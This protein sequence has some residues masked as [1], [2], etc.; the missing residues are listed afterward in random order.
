MYMFKKYAYPIL[1]LE[2]S[3]QKITRVSINT[4]IALLVQVLVVV[5]SLADVQGRIKNIP[6]IDTFTCSTTGFEPRFTLGYDRDKTLG[7]Q[8]WS[9]FLLTVCQMIRGCSHHH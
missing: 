8:V 6:G 4:M 9:F 7:W 2:K 5:L 3:D 1:C